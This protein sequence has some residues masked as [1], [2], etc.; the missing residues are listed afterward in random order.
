MQIDINGTIREMTAEEE[1][2]YMNDQYEYEQQELN[3][4][5]TALEL[6]QAQMLYTALLT[7]TLVEDE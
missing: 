4:P 6:L 5:P 1:Q 7:D 3:R 2:L